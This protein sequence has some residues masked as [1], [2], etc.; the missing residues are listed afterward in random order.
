[1]YFSKFGIAT[2]ALFLSTTPFAGQ[3]L[4]QENENKKATIEELLPLCESGDAAVCHDLHVRF[5][6]GQGVDADYAK[7]FEF[8]KKACE[9]DNMR[10]CY[11]FAY[12]LDRGEGATKDEKRAYTFFLK[13]CEGDYAR[14]C[15]EVGYYN[16]NG[17][18]REKNALL[19]A[20][21]YKKGCDLDLAI[22]CSNYAFKLLK[23]IGVGKDTQLAID[24]FIKSCEGEYGQGCHNLGHTYWDLADEGKVDLSKARPALVRACELGEDDACSHVKDIDAGLSKPTIE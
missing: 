21:Y 23:G 1:M 12:A 13:S 3:A 4:A 11:D 7:A 22:S 16:E 9:L 6:E 15:N 10:G 2:A 24:L 20:G 17:V 14:S 5:Y 18:K 8:A 19:A